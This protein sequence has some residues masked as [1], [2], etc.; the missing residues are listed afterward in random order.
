ME[1]LFFSRVFRFM[2]TG[3]SGKMGISRKMLKQQ[4]T[5]I[6]GQTNSVKANGYKKTY[7]QMNGFSIMKLYVRTT[8]KFTGTQ[9]DI[10][11]LQL[12]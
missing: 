12:A 11:Q 7:S 9:G 6:Y 5:K 4:E 2:V 1:C 3:I 10:P 8:A